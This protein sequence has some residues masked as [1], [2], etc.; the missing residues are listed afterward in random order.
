MCFLPA[1]NGD[2]TVWPFIEAPQLTTRVTGELV[3][4]ANSQHLY[5][6]ITGFLL[7]QRASIVDVS[8]RFDK[9]YRSRLPTAHIAE[10]RVEGGATIA[11]D[12]IDGYNFAGPVA[13]S[14]YLNRVD[15]Y[16]K[17][18]FDAASHAN[19]ANGSR[20]VPFGLNYPVTVNHRFF[21][22]LGPTGL[23]GLPERAARLIVGAR[24]LDVS[25][26]E[27]VPRHH[28][29]PQ[30]LFQTRTW[31]PAE[32]AETNDDWRIEREQMN[33]MR[34]SCV[35]LLRQEFGSRFHGGFMPTEHARRNFPDCVV[36]AEMAS[37][38]RYMQTLK[39]TDICIATAGLHGSN[40]WRVRRRQQGDRQ[41]AVAVRRAGISRRAPLPRLLDAAGVRRCR[42][43]PHLREVAAAQDE[44]RE[45]RLLPPV[46]APGS[47]GAELAAAGDERPR[48]V[49]AVE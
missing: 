36:G 39:D 44:D 4:S 19:V 47:A 11:Y 49:S 14:E 5:Q 1:T 7:L 16:F 3:V 9:D 27:D 13:L 35:R 33:E 15:C 8:L 38:R 24:S 34:A 30:V 18:S 2:E 31:D 26:F 25:R 48:S 23:L 12:M 37:K 45:L 20:I 42:L 29:D 17:R 22:G 46:P 32:V 41:P 28:S 21:A 6:V 40:G 43:D 10:L